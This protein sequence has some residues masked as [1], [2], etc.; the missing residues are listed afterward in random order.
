MIE[1]TLYRRGSPT[2]RELC[3]RFGVSCRGVSLPLQRAAV[4][5]GAD[6]DHAPVRKSYRYLHNRLE[7]VDYRGARQSKL[8]I[9]SGAVE[10]G[11]RHVIQARLKLAGRWWNPAS[12]DRM[13][14]LRPYRA[15]RNWDDYW[16]NVARQAT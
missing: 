6:E 3:V 1:E 15:N 11:H 7:Q 2:V 8:P 5:F 13:L 9:G 16:D 14:A 12:I 10:S 4:D